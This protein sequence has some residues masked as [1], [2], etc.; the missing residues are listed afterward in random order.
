MLDR[1][2][3]T[4]SRGTL[5]QPAKQQAMQMIS[6]LTEDVDIEEIMYRLYVLENMRKGKEDAASGRI[7]DSDDFKREIEQW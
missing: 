6:L 7:T 5:M 2:I 3:E 4:L 1:S